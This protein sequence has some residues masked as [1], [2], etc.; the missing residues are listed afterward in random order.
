MIV[1]ARGTE[2]EEDAVPSRHR[3]HSE[4]TPE[5]VVVWYSEDSW[6]EAGC[7]LSSVGRWWCTRFW[8]SQVSIGTA[9]WCLPWECGGWGGVRIT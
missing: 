8:T 7:C 9:G 2:S 3:L 6:P 5:T 1:P 4:D